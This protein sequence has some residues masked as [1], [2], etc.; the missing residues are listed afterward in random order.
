MAKTI[1]V[2][3]AA[4]FL[5]SHMCDYLLAKG[6]NVIG[7]DNLVTGAEE[8]LAE[9]KLNKNFKFIKQDIS[10]KFELTEKIDQIYN[11]ACPAS[12]IDYQK[13]PVETLLV[14]SYGMR[15]MLE[16]AKKHNARILQA[17]T[18]EVYGDPAVHP[19]TEEYWGNVNS[20]GLRSCYDESKRFS[21]AL[22]MAYQR[23][24]KMETRIVR[25]FNTYGPKMRQ[26]DGRVVSNFIV[27]ALAGEPITVYGEGNQTR[28]FCYV[29]DLIEGIHRL[30]NSDYSL[31]VNIGNPN[32]FT[33]LELAEKVI[34]L[35]NSKSKIVKEPLPSDDPAR[36][37]PDITKAKKIL[38]WEPK[39]Q[40]EEGLKRTVEYFMRN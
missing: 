5:G 37:Q 15:N 7:M 25:I 17:S 2:T 9:A 31:P 20:I 26:D 39:V 10:E 40:L 19:Q 23:T 14:G 18:S 27:Q 33:I 35:T 13:L 12:P 24:H 28:S 32:E 6:H 21:E 3:G 16:F 22:V 38:K 29:S 8:N 30:M 11:M 1:L 36:R 34:A 4:G